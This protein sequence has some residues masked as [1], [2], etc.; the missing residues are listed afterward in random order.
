[1]ICW[2]FG[3]YLNYENYLNG[4]SLQCV[5]RFLAAVALDYVMENRVIL[6][7]GI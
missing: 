3:K 7:I 5:F 4:S 6:K 2:H 1:M